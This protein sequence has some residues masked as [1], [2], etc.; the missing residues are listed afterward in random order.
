MELRLRAR[1][2]ILRFFD[3]LLRVRQRVADRMVNRPIEFPPTAY[4]IV[5]S[6]VGIAAAVFLIAKGVRR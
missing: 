1:G 4:M 2:L 3:G 6:I 5:A